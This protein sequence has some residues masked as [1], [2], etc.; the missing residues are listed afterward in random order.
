MILSLLVEGGGINSIARITGA[1]KTTVLRLL[2]EAGWFSRIYQAY[3]F[4]DLPWR[5]IEA[6]EIWS[7]VEAK[8]MN[9]TRPGAGRPVDVDR[10]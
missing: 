9:A 10:A 1:A 4:R 3:R 6:D 5:R 7:F 2:V 8:A